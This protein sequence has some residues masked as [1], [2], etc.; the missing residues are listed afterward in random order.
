M[1]VRELRPPARPL[2]DGQCLPDRRADPFPGRR[3]A[4]SGPRPRRRGEV[5]ERRRLRAARRH[6]R[7]ARALGGRP[8][9]LHG[10]SRHPG[11]VPARRRNHPHQRSHAG[12]GDS[13]HERSDGQHRTGTQALDRGVRGHTGPARP[14]PDPGSGHRG[15]RNTRTHGNRV[16]PPPGRQTAGELFGAVPELAEPPEN[17]EL[18][19]GVAGAGATAVAGAQPPTVPAGP[20]T[21]PDDPLAGA[22]DEGVDPADEEDDANADGV[23]AEEPLPAM[24]AEFPGGPARAVG[25]EDLTP[26]GRYRAAVTDDPDFVWRVPSARML[27]RSTGEAA[28]PDTAGQEQVA[29]NL[30]ETPGPLRNR[31]PGH[32]PGHRAAHH[33]LRASSR[34]GHQGGQ[35]GPAQ[36]RSGL[37]AGRHRHPDPRSDPR[38]AGGRRRGAQRPAADRPPGRRL[39]TA[40]AGLV[41]AHRVAGQGHRRTGD[42]GR[43]DQDAPPARRRHHRRRQVGVRERHALLGPPAGHPARGPGRPRRSQ[44]GRAQPLRV[45]SPPAHAGH[46]EP[47]HGRER[48]AEPGQG[49]G[50]ALRGD[51]PGPDALPARAQPRPRTPR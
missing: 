7:T 51:V 33:P 3:D 31:G 19:D 34:T 22:D 37:F 44:A 47:P 13:R 45:D 49:D 29:R 23:A 6:P 16:P 39:S 8:S 25:P 5:L 46:H 27:V 30:V 17:E 9:P 24:D 42:R 18:P 28:K 50:A 4:W 15:A 35:G 41:A 40:A 1:L 12:R 36:G 21:E 11:R 48:P 2:A 32:R 14:R 20:L 10:G 38:Q 26:Q 43:P